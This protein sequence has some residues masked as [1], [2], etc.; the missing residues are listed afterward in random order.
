MGR[1]AA[2]VALAVALVLAASGCARG[3]WIRQRPQL[4]EQARRDPGSFLGPARQLTAPLEGLVGSYT[5]RL[6]RGIG[7]RTVD[8]FVSVR[9]PADLDILVLDP[10]GGTQAYLRA[11]K[12]EVGLFL[13]EEKLLY[14]GPSTR[15]SFEQAIGFGLSAADVVAALLG[16]AIDTASHPPGQPTWDED[17]RRI[18]VDYGAEASVWLLP[19]TLGFDRVEHRRAGD[20]VMIEV[21]ESTSTLVGAQTVPLPSSLRLRIEPDGYGIALQLLDDPSPNFDFPANHFDLQVPAGVLQLPIS[22]LG[23]EGGL[24]RRQ[25]PEEQ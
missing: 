14:R 17:A 24:F 6:S 12:L 25:A 13:R 21:L 3:G 18:R 2:G 4:A 11:N 16:S 8:T 1:V 7:R 22:D 20:S 19:P 23:R 9:R 10:S 5:M 15:A